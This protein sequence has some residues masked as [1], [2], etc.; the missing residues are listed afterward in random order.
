MSKQV[1]SKIWINGEWYSLGNQ[2]DYEVQVIDIQPGDS[3]VH[4]VNENLD[5]YNCKE[6][7]D[8][9]EKTYPNNPII[10]CHKEML[11]NITILR[12]TEKINSVNDK[13]II[14]DPYYAYP[15]AENKNTGL[16]PGDI[17]W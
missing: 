1:I 5:L 6:L 3:I 17:L 8:K 7:F 10:F 15:F 14:D 11:E 16:R 2:K 12:Q 4:H 13:I 9:F